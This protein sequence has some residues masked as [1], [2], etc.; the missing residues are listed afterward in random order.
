[1]GP[2][3]TGHADRLAANLLKVARATAGLSQRELADAAHV[4]QSTIAR[5]ESGAMQPSLPV[6]ARILAAIDVEMRI[7][8]AA[9][10]NHDDVL[11]AEES[12][13][14]AEQRA[15]RQATQDRFITQLQE[16]QESV[17]EA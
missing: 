17:A 1:M 11:D 5:I 9:Y 16:S 7:T 14:S 12:R 4:A 10:D 15:A 8:L 6:L 2:T 3:A 13:L